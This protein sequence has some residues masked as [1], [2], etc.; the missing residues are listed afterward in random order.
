VTVTRRIRATVFLSLIPVALCICAAGLL[1][2]ERPNILFIT[3]DDMNCD[4]VGAFGCELPGTTPHIDRLAS[5]GLRFERAFVQVANCMPSRNVMYSGRYPHSNRVE[6]FYQV[7]DAAYPVL[8]DLMQQGG[9]FTAI[10]GKVSHSTPYSPYSW[11]LVLDTVGQKPH[12][13]DVQS[14]YRSTRQG[15]AAADEAGQ[16]FCLIVNVSDPHKPFFG[17]G[18]GGQEID[19]PHKTSR[20]FTAEEVPVP[21]FLPDAPAVRKELAHYYSS[22]RR[23][24]DCVGEVLRALRESGQAEATVVIFLSDHGMP[25]PFAKTALYYHSTHTPWIVRWPGRVTANTV[26]SKHMISAVDLTPT[27]LDIAGIKHPP[28]FQGRSF[29]PLLDGATQEGRD[30]VILEYNENAGGGRNPMRSVVT[31]RFGYIF[32]PW[33]N[34]TRTFRTATTGTLTYRKMKELADTDPEMAARVDLFDH[35]VLE[36][37]YDYENDPDALHNLIDDPKHQDEINR[38]RGELE[39]WMVATGDHAL[40]ALR[41]RDD[42]EAVEAYASR[43]QAEADARRQESRKQAR[44]ATQAARQRSKKLIKLNVPE[45]VEASSPLTL[46]I[47]YK[48]SDALGAQKLH[49]TLKDADNRRIVR[50]VREI[51]GTGSLEVVFRVP[52]HRLGRAVRFAA[53]VGDDYQT[54]LQHI[55][56]DPVPVK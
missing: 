37:F 48:L 8:C 42:Q 11:D 51:K 4:S 9:Y 52:P 27:L 39:R 43:V 29:L 31:R 47:D 35:R 49:V 41:N 14:Y 7:K 44:G 12:P 50:E 30:Q 3:V 26:D 33:S 10:R 5:E 20:V 32:N 23:A 34:G 28:G 15:I 1:A 45:A 46:S 36:E 6:G 54:H 16:P 55:V 13:K 19:D 21:G 2:A 24:D 56:S 25:F 53:F 40:V 38:L 18:R 22:V 17:M